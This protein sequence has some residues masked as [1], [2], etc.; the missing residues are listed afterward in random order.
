MSRVRFM[1]PYLKGGRDTAKLSNR[2]RYIATRPG[3]EVLRGKQQDQP[4]TKK[5]QAYIQSLLRDF[6]GAKELLEYE[7][8]CNAPTQANANTFIRQV[9]E[10]FAEPMSRMENYLDYVS[11]RP[12]V[13]MDGEHGLWCARGK[14][15]NLSQAVRGVAEHTGSVWTPVVAIRREDAERL[16]YNDAESWRQ[17][18]C[19]CAPEIARGYKIPLEHL[20]WY[21]AFHRKEDSVHIHMVVF[22]SNLKEGYLTKQGIRQVKSAFGRRIFR[23]D[24]LHIYEQK[25][26]YRDALG[27]DAERTMA[28][29]IAQMETGQLQNENLEQPILE[30]SRRLQN[31]KGKTVYGYLPPTAKALVDAIVDELAKEER[32]AAAYDLWNQMREEVYR[33]YSEQLPERLLLSKQKEFKA[34]RNMVVREVLQLGRGEHPTADEIVHMPT[35][36]GTPPA[37]SGLPYGAHH[38]QQEAA[39]HQ[40]TQTHRA[41]SHAD[42]ARCVLQLFHSMGRIF[43]EQSASDAIQTGLHIDRK[44]RRMLREKRMA[45]GH[46]ADDHEEIPQ[47]SQR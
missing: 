3:V 22:S 6:P 36:S 33:T 37:Q 16:G 26:K 1:S 28:E 20:R 35:P 18:V 7:D 14:V 43:R 10:D 15:R 19:A 25:T 2:T 13:Q 32:V 42:T 46:K 27:R 23:Q 17:L 30:L 41:V 38:P 34:V 24:L 44:R 9:Q 8:Y 12:G 45:L 5:Q 29:L 39:Y 21:A 40:R 47:H 4:A 11:H 31:T